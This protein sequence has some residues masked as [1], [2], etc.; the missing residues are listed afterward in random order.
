MRF[1]LIRRIMQNGAAVLGGVFVLASGAG[2]WPQE[3]WLNTYRTC[4]NAVE[5]LRL[6]RSLTDVFW[7]SEEREYLETWGEHPVVLTFNKTLWIVARRNGFAVIAMPRF[8]V[9][10]KDVPAL[11]VIT[12]LDPQSKLNLYELWSADV[13]KATAAGLPVSAFPETTLLALPASRLRDDFRRLLISEIGNAK[14]S[15][16]EDAISDPKS[17]P[18]EDFGR[19]MTACEKDMDEKDDVDLLHQ[20]RSKLKSRHSSGHP[21]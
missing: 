1:L 20:I 3:A 10:P 17:V 4:Q 15:A 19:E 21:R 14:V 18:A 5:R 16:R 6:G 9:R 13:T 2:A 12:H 8:K 11:Y 7:G